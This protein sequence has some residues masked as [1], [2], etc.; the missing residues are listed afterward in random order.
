MGNNRQM[1][2][3]IRCLTRV[4]WRRLQTVQSQIQNVV[5]RE[6]PYMEGF[7]FIRESAARNQ[8]VIWENPEIR[9]RLCIDPFQ[10]R[11]RI[12]KGGLP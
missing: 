3:R 6:F 9:Y 7:N 12:F 4:K 1:D 5:V 11:R 2:V 10:R 8:D